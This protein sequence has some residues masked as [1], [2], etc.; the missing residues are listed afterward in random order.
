MLCR[1]ARD[2][3]RAKSSQPLSNLVQKPFEQYGLFLVLTLVTYQVWDTTVSMFHEVS[4][5]PMHTLQCQGTIN[6]T[7]AS[8]HGLEKDG[9]QESSRRAAAGGG[10]AESR[11]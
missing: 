4:T 1:S 11:Q 2:H 8:V 5:I 3:F 9:Q 7:M 10:S 6:D